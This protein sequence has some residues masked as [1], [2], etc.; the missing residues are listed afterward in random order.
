MDT[1]AFQLELAKIRE[2][3]NTLTISGKDNAQLILY[4]VE[5]CNAVIAALND[6]VITSKE[7]SDD[8]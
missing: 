5:K 3:T 7:G 4:I 6:V 1:K 8:Q 2:A